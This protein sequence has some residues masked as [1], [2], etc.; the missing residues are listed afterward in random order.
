MFEH[1]REKPFTCKVCESEFED[2]ESVKK[3]V[4]IHLED[5]EKAQEKRKLR[6]RAKRSK[7]WSFFNKNDS[8][9]ATCN[10]CGK[11]I[12]CKSGSTTNLHTHLQRKH[13]FET[14]SAGDQ[15]DSASGPSPV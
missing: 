15:F 12:K 2:G 13:G 6:K 11:D 5:W 1:T 3:H 10:L 8:I 14:E 9:S 7:V 4:K